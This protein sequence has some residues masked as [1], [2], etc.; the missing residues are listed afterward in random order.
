MEVSLLFYPWGFLGKLL[1]L[2]RGEFVALDVVLKNRESSLDFVCVSTNILPQVFLSP[3]LGGSLW[4]KAKLP[5]YPINKFSDA[6][7]G[8]RG[9]DVCFAP[10][11]ISPSYC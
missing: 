7:K 6:A 2:V 4:L 10:G 1:S 9:R 8:I 11:L 5:N 3:H